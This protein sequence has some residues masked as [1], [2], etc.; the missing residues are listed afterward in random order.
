MIIINRT[1]MDINSILNKYHYDTMQQDIINA[2]NSSETE[3]K[4]DSVNQL[5]FELMLRKEIVKSA[6]ELS[7]SGIEFQ[8][9]EKSKCN[10]KY[11]D[12]QNDGGFLLKSGVTPS[13]AIR[14]IFI[15]ASLYATECST[16]IVIIYYKALL[17]VFK[18]ERFNK[19][20]PKIRLKNWHSLDNLLKEGGTLK[21][22]ND[23]LPG[24]RRYIENPD[25]DPKLPEYQGENI[26]DIGHGLYYGH[27]VGVSNLETIINELNKFRI[28]HSKKSAF[29]KDSA[30]RLN[31]KK[32]SAVYYNL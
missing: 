10:P 1:K 32:L 15:N 2:L 9:F 17:N 5:K 26:V 3:Y 12:R 25:V 28:K 18:K 11:W 6:N 8:V 7:E 20:F 22:E 4:Y 24:D 14:D 31:F 29:L 13:D 27:G 21:K 16:A 23:Y 19:I 30:A